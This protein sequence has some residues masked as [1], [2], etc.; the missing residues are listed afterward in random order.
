MEVLFSGELDSMGQGDITSDFEAELRRRNQIQSSVLNLLRP[1]FDDV[2]VH[3][4]VV[5]NTNHVTTDTRTPILTQEEGNVGAMWHRVTS[6]E[7]ATST[8]GVGGEPGLG[9]NDGMGNQYQTGGQSGGE[10]AASRR[11]I[12]EHWE[13]GWEHEVIRHSFG[14]LVPGDSSLAIIGYVHTTFDQAR[15]EDNGL[16]GDQTWVEFVEERRAMMPLDI[17]DTLSPALL[18]GVQAASGIENVAIAAFELFYFSDRIEEPTDWQL[19]VV[20][21]L[22]AILIAFLAISLFRKNQAEEVLEVAPELSVEGLL[23]STQLEEEEE[24][25]AFDPLKDID[26]NDDSDVKRQIDKFV[27]ER[28]DAVAQLL[29][30]WL[31]DSWE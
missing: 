31:N 7:S 15:M 2:R 16:L 20:L 17:T 28:P 13:H 19:F 18:A 3:P 14:D 22:L 11:Q 6:D 12:E 30:N 24:A 29:R 23:V 1:H 27:E 25:A 8:G 26:Y 21:A 9:S 4:H 10:S 5:V